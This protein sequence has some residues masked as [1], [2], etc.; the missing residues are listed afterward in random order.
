VAKPDRKS[1]ELA[2]RL[3]KT[4]GGEPADHEWAA[5]EIT[6]GKLT[7]GQYRKTWEMARKT[8][9]A[10]TP[11]PAPAASEAPVADPRVPVGKTA[12]EVKDFT[13]HQWGVPL[14]EDSASQW[15]SLLGQDPKASE[16][17]LKSMG[18]QAAALYPP[19]AE[20]LRGGVTAAALLDGY[21]QIAKDELGQDVE[22]GDPV[23]RTAGK[24][25]ESGET[26]RE[27]LR[28]LPEWDQGPAAAK[29]SAQLVQAFKS[30][31]GWQ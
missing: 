30:Q 31:E 23:F 19:L 20:A 21:S 9:Q 4:W 14:S 18:Q 7:E 13:L 24:A 11:E 27:H 10:N 6:A 8:A 12:A 1:E 5:R 28:S 3:A 29:E 2:V 26:F 25:L 15:A 17:Y 22:I 16:F